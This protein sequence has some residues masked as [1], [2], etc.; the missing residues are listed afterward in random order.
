ML[1]RVLDPSYG[2][3]IRQRLV[4]L[5]VART[6][7]NACFR[8]APPFLAT[9]AAGMGASLQRIGI[10][11]AISELSGLASPAVGMVAER[12]QRRVA[13]TVGL[14]GVAAG[15]VLAAALPHLVVFA[16]AL[17]VIGQSKAL[18]DLGLAA[19]ISDRVPY[20]RRGR[21]MGL[22][23]SSWALGLLVGVAG[24]GLVTAA[25]SWRV[26]YL[27]GA[28]AVAVLA[29]AVNRMVAPDQPGAGGIVRRS[30]VPF[31]GSLTRQAPVLIAAV[32]CL[33][34]ASQVLFVTFGSWLGDSFGFGEVE[35]SAVAFGLGFCELA[36][37]LG[38]ARF[39]DGWGKERA[40]AV[41]AGIMV[42]AAL[43]L[44]GLNG[45]LVPGLLLLFVAIGAF[46]FA[47]V[48]AIPLATDLVRGAPAKGVA[49]MFGAGTLGRA[50]VTIPATGLYERYGMAWPALG[51]AVL[52][53]ATIVAMRRLGS[54]RAAG[55]LTAA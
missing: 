14:A 22:N 10:A 32:F 24:L 52:G 13:M 20:E 19:W 41:G 15:A 28:A 51:C 31:R 12:L 26:A 42:P 6:A 18:F 34:A 54:S 27:V 17:V 55:A 44:M 43:L 45:F 40:A 5:T 38:A 46:E 50:L 3:E 53:C 2:A 21:V 39:T 25:L 36:A 47:I 33:M 49:L 48:S 7:A 4:V 11:V 29:I 8:F 16:V 37:A 23:E 9:I 1:D 30:P 35:L